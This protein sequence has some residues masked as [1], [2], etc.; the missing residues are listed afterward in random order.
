MVVAAVAAIVAAAVV[1]VAVAVV[2]RLPLCLLQFR[3]RLPRVDH[4]RCCHQSCGYT[5]SGLSHVCILGP[6]AHWCSIC[7]Q[8]KPHEGFVDE[9]AG[10]AEVQL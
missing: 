10:L 8:A 4:C 9:N 6:R 3:S 7:S 1:A 2:P 5:C